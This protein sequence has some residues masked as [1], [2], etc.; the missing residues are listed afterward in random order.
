MQAASSESGGTLC[1]AV[2]AEGI[3]DGRVS[4]VI[5]WAAF[6]G[7]R[8][9]ELEGGLQRLGSVRR[10]PQR[11]SSLDGKET[12]VSRAGDVSGE[13]TVAASVNVR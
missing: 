9:R 4:E 5:A 7:I 11:W 6:D 3:R 8:T 1:A 12:T 2:T 13:G 10:A